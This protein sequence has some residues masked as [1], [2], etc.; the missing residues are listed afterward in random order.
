MRRR[1]SHHQAGTVGRFRPLMEWADDIRRWGARQCRHPDRR[2]HGRATSAPRASACA[3]PSTCSSI[4]E[5]ITAVREMILSETR[6]S[7]AALAKLLPMQRGTSSSC[8]RSW[9]A[10]R[11]PSACSIRRCTSSCRMAR[12]N[13]GS[14]RQHGTLIRA[15]APASRAGRV[16]PDARPPRLPA[17]GLYPEI[18]EMQARA[19]FR[20]RDGT[21]QEGHRPGA[22][23]RK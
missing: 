14:G 8:S 5:R 21:G 17:C 22:H 1:N 12:K 2:P 19:I 10:C 4:G 15:R 23:S 7:A 9:Q 18:A 13:S 20:G 16:Q 3:A 11:S 6:P